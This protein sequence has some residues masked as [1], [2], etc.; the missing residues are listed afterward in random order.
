M[1]ET[2]KLKI[3]QGFS[4]LKK[5]RKNLKLLVC[6][7]GP[8]P[9]FSTLVS[10]P[11]TI[12]IFANHSY[13]YLKK[14]NLDGIDIDWEFPVW[15]RDARK[16]DRTEFTLLLKASQDIYFPGPPTITKVAYDVPSFNR[17][18]DLVQVMNYD[19]H[20]FSYLFPFVGFNAPL[21]R[22]NGE[23]GIAG[24]MNSEAAMAE[25]AKMGL[26]SNKT[27]F[28]IPAYGLG[29]RLANWRVNKP[30][31]PATSTVDD[32]TNFDEICK[33][34]ADRQRYTYVW[35]EQAASPYI[36]GNFHIHGNKH[37]PTDHI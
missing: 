14:F 1:C 36:H 37:I 12:S 23:A 5:R 21:R 6:I 30:Y 25:Y 34:L 8:N 18:V 11:G 22:L 7:T 32:Y 29:Y 24:K 9:A 13:T 17:Y 27:V 4:Q 20:V 35:N 19:F 2:K 31:A 10:S 33:L 26:W 28:G 16:T 15:S 3:F